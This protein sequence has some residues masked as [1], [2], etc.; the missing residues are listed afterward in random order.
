MVGRTSQAVPTATASRPAVG[1]SLMA[2]AAV[3]AKKTITALHRDVW[4]SNSWSSRAPNPPAVNNM[5]A[6]MAG[7]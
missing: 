3:Q 6:T 4:G 2:S 5:A 7:R 1:S